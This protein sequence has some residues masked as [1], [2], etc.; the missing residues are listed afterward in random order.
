MNEKINNRIASISPKKK[1]YLILI[2]IYLLCLLIGTFADPWTSSPD[3]IGGN[4]E[5]YCEEHIPFSVNTAQDQFLAVMY[6]EVYHF[7]QPHNGHI[8]KL[9]MKTVSFGVENLV[10]CYDEAL[11]DYATDILAVTFPMIIIIKTLICKRLFKKEKDRVELGKPKKK[12]FRLLYYR[13]ENIFAEVL[14]DYIAFFAIGVVARL[15][16]MIFTHIGVGVISQYVWLQAFLFSIYHMLVIITMPIYKSTLFLIGFFYGVYEQAE[17]KYPY[18]DYLYDGLILPF[19][20]FPLLNLAIV[21]C[22]EL[23]LRIVM[24]IYEAVFQLIKNIIKKLTNTIDKTINGNHKP[25]Q[26]GQKI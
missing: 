18:M 19:I 14:A 17:F 5:E 26:G 13:S 15:I 20:I 6:D 25:Y 2:G 9:M 16:F 22:F 12:R 4:F 21:I 11:M 23:L 3:V 8:I 7:E 24:R 1:K 10:I